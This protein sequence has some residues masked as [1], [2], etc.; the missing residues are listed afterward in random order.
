MSF[1]KSQFRGGVAVLETSLTLPVVLLMMFFIFEMI[2]INSIKNAMDSMVTEAVLD[3]ISSKNTINFDAIVEK[4]RPIFIEREKIR[5]YFAIYNDMNT[6][7]QTAPYGNEDI[8]WPDAQGKKESS[9]PFLSMGNTFVART[10]DMALKDHTRPELGF[11]AGVNATINNK[12]FVLTF[13]CDYKFSSEMIGRAFA[14]GSNCKGLPEGQA[15]FLMWG[16]GVGITN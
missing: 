2:R 14:G 9:A 8:Y 1:L 4:H 16:R 3:F 10:G 5:Y 15:R 7:C 6:M 12:V 11:A 13:V